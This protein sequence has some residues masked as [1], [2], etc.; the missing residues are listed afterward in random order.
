MSHR[1]PILACLAV[2][3]LAACGQEPAE[4][5]TPAPAES[6]AAPAPQ[7]ELVPSGATAAGSFDQKG[8]AG[9]FEGTLPCADCP[10][11]DTSLELRAD[12][13]YAITERYQERPASNSGD[14]TWTVEDQD[15]TIRLDPNSKSEPDRLYRIESPDR[16]VQLGADGQPIDSGLDYGL[17]RAR[18]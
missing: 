1:L 7:P 17:S 4:P 5:A 15:R 6:V 16:I 8:F 10:G 2:L 9:T 13:S 3:G 12:G 11:I 18:R 14:G